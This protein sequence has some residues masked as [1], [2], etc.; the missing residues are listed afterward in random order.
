MNQIAFISKYE[1]A[2]GLWRDFY[3]SKEGRLNYI[4][5]KSQTHYI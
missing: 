4:R 5:S 3:L 1:I 2:N